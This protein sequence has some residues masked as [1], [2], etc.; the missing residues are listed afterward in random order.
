MPFKKRILKNDPIHRL[1][2]QAYKLRMKNPQ[3]KRQAEIRRK[4]YYRINKNKMKRYNKLYRKAIKT[5]SDT[6]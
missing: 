3:E 5:R 6:H 4:A 1:E 2:R